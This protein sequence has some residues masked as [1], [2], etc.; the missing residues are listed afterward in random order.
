MAKLS[1]ESVT[2]KNF[3]SFGAVPQTLDFTKGL[4]IIMGMDVERN[5]SN[6]AGKSSTLDTIPF[7]LFGKTSRAVTKAGLVNFKN[8]K[9]CSVS[10]TFHKDGT[11]YVVNRT[12]KP[13]SL[14]I[15]RNDVLIPPPSNV[16]D[17]QQMFEDDILGFDFQT[18]MTL[19]HTNLN[20]IIP[21]LKM[22]VPEKRKFLER[23]FNLGLFSDMVSRGNEKIRSLQESIGKLKLGQ[24]FSNQSI[25][26]QEDQLKKLNAKR[27]SMP[28]TANE[29]RDVKER[30]NDIQDKHEDPAGRSKSLQEKMDV[31]ETQLVELSKLVLVSKGVLGKMKG[32][33]DLLEKQLKTYGNVESDVELLKQARKVFTEEFGSG[34]SVIQERTELDNRMVVLQANKDRASKLITDLKVEHQAILSDRKNIWSQLELL[35]GDKCPTCQGDLKDNK[36]LEELNQKFKV[37]VNQD[38]I[39]VGELTAAEIQQEQRLI[40]IKDMKS[41]ILRVKKRVIEHDRLKT[42]IERLSPAETRQFEYIHLKLDLSNRQPLMNDEILKLQKLEN[43]VKSKTGI[44]KSCKD[45]LDGLQ[46]AVNKLSALKD[47]LE[48]LERR[49]EEEVLVV[50]DLQKMIDD[51]EQKVKDLTGTNREATNKINKL[52]DL[53]DYIQYVKEMCQDDGVKQYAVTSYM[54]YLTSRVNH[55]L[56]ESGCNF[57][58]KL[59]GWLEEEIMGAGISNCTYGN[60][61]GGETR[62]IDIALQLAFLDIARIKAGVFPDLMVFDELLDSSVDGPGITSM[63]RI[64]KTL[65]REIDG[66]VFLITHRSEISDIDIDNMYVVEKSGGFSH[67]RKV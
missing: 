20:A 54:P 47:Q 64:I 31:A 67:V 62:S 55:Y 11:K 42:Q 9:G 32:E 21:V 48:R 60:L 4:N 58:I 18:F 15:F 8:K 50:Y 65:Q 29:I 40:D 16:R 53:M 36:L 30:I 63:M 35:N 14:E 28:N 7:A 23:I 45:E 26:E 38:C 34:A 12:I 2:F 10:L 17:Y 66:K 44:I 61:S 43:D 56:S 27:N 6:A 33:Y 5:R 37:V 19:L 24:D 49:L 25:K 41:E 13:D 51:C 22:S 57:Y 3:L 46:S 1:F 59:T 39:T 52:N